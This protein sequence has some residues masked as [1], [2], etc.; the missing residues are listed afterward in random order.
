M[1]I[2]ITGCSGYIGSYVVS[3]LAK[4]YPNA[5]YIL[6]DKFINE[7]YMDY[8]SIKKKSNYNFH[9]VDILSDNI[10]P[11]FRNAN[12]VIH[13]SAIIDKKSL[14]DDKGTI[15]D[16]NIECTSKIA[17]TCTQTSSRMIALSSASVYGTNSDKVPE[18]CSSE[19]INPQSQYAL[20][21]LREEEVINDLCLNKGLHAT[22][23]RFASIF[24]VSPHMKFHTVIN[25]FCKQAVLS[26]PITIWRTAFEQKRPYLDIIDASNAISFLIDNDFFDGDTC[27]VSTNTFTVHHIVNTIKKYIP[28]VK[29][30]FVDEPIMNEWSYGVSCDRLINSGFV[31]TGDLQRGIKETIEYIRLN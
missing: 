31:F 5:E 6:V 1:K 26:Q 19:D 3:N 17:K 8:F 23:F 21:K 28:N 2:V 24:G 27:N 25:K 14:E 13:L 30:S 12:F 9:E 22:I 7:N 4:K 11:L 20:S 10:L 18:E 29:I 16:E 15:F